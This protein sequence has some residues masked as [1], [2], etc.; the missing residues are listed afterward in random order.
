MHCENGLNP[1]GVEYL[2]DYVDYA[3]QISR[4]LGLPEMYQQGDAVQP[5]PFTD[6]DVVTMFEILDACSRNKTKKRYSKYKPNEVVQTAE[7]KQEK[8]RVP[9]KS[10][11]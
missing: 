11:T 9:G 7:L 4:D 10:L 5:L 3:N 8:D 6:V 1:I 2:K